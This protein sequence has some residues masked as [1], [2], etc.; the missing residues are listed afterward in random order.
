M[1]AEKFLQQLNKSKEIPPVTLLLGEEI[2][3]VDKIC[4]AIEK[5]WLG[6]NEDA[7]VT[8][9]QTDPE[10]NVLR[11]MVNEY[12]FFSDRSL[13]VIEQSNLFVTNKQLSDKS[14]NKENYLEVLKDVPDFCRVVIKSTKADKRTKLFKNIATIGTVVECDK[15]KNYKIKP[16]LIDAAKTYN[17]TWEEDALDYVVDYLA[18]TEEISLY[19]LVQELEKI[20]LYIG[21]D[22]VW[23]RE[24]VAEIFSD[25]QDLSGFVLIKSMAEGD[26][27]KALTILREQTAQGEHM[28]KISGLI[29]FQLRRFLSV[30][31]ILAKGGSREE[32]IK[33]AKI[34]PFLVDELIR[35]CK[36]IPETK[37]KRAILALSDIN[38]EVHIGGRGLVHLEETI[39]EFC[40]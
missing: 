34:P 16:W 30:S 7:Q 3:Y 13:I 5:I 36:K 19:S 38:R 1:D 25:V 6:D 22:T 27:S 10:A 23:T 4:K 8:L 12:S 2:Y 17:C 9:L 18:M 21:S 11:D 40:L 33:E 28:L 26:A 39:V 31:N 29:A 37:I 35:Q 24:K 32:V 20:S 15:I 14:K